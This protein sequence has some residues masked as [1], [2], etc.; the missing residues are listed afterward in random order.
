VSLRSVAPSH[1]I[2]R[3]PPFASP[4]VTLSTPAFSAHAVPPP[5][6]HPM[7]IPGFR[8]W[9]ALLFS[10]IVYGSTKGFVSYG[11]FTHVG[12]PLRASVSPPT[13]YPSSLQL[14]LSPLSSSP[15]TTFPSSS[16]SCSP[17]LF[18]QQ[19]MGMPSLVG[20]RRQ[21]PTP[22]V[23]PMPA[24]SEGPPSEGCVLLLLSLLARF[25]CSHLR[26]LAVLET[27]LMCSAYV[28][29]GAQEIVFP[30]CR[31]WFQ[32][33]DGQK[34]VASSVGTLDRSSASTLLNQV[35]CEQHPLFF[36]LSH[37]ELSL[38]PNR[39]QFV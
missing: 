36:F 28:R 12:L 1:P 7:R 3:P 15:V 26:W 37:H 24:M 16:L 11:G 30:P 25:T 18:V 21:M 33:E 19:T 31:L 38:L 34:S 27:V 14:P 4:S 13:L 2:A 35:R 6:H 22:T 17:L 32:F 10:C 20:V 39:W 9:S 5:P 29:W 8:P 23:A